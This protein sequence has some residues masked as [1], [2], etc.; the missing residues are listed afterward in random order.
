MGSS[1]ESEA[2]DEPLGAQLGA[3]SNVLLLASDQ[4]HES[5]TCASLLSV[6]G[7]EDVVHL[8][9]TIDDTPD[10]R[11]DFWQSEVGE[12]PS[13][14]AIIA[15]GETTRSAAASSSSFDPTVSAVSFDSVADP[16]DLT[17][18]SMAISNFIG[19]WK[20]AG[21][22]P[23]VCFDS[24]SS[25]LLHG[26]EE[27]IFRFLHATTGRLRD[28]GAVAHYHLNPSAFE[29]STVNTFAALFDAI[30]EVNEDGSISVRKRR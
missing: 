28:I 18:L 24:I 19:A 30:V 4:N 3:A 25:L 20:G 14:T 16:S 10:G 27:R 21:V 2:N 15:V 12:L 9:V 1:A 11:L 23:V 5:A 22:T 29:E 8:S 17:G 13:E 26:D 7:P 6:D